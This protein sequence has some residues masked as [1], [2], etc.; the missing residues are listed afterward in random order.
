M[1]GRSWIITGMALNVVRDLRDRT[2]ALEA[3][4]ANLVDGDGSRLAIQKPCADIEASLQGLKIRA[5]SVMWA[6][7]GLEVD[8]GAVE[9]WSV[10]YSYL[11]E[12]GLAFLRRHPNDDDMKALATFDGGTLH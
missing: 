1:N 12:H 4:L 6:D 5:L 11:D 2:A 3:R 10:D 8:P 7:L 9:T